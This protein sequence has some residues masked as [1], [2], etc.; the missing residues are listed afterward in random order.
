[1]TLKTPIARSCAVAMLVTALGIAG[2]ASGSL[3]VSEP[4]TQKMTFSAAHVVSGDSTVTVDPQASQAFETH[5]RNYLYAGKGAKF[6][7]GDQLTISYRFVQLNK[8]NQATRYF[9]GFGA[10]KGTLTIE[11]TF[12]S[13]DG[14]QL[15]KINVGGEIS[16][17][18][19]GGD[20]E[21][22]IDKA[23]QQAASYALNNFMA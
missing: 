14:R 10:G 8:G 18:F 3:M 21:S 9:I 7:E 22:A 15:G 17:G 16:G 20:F 5:L 2:C 12:K 1:M 6:S 11:V 13:R 4:P 23:A 19:F